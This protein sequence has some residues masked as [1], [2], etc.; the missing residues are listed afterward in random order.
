[1]ARTVLSVV[2]VLAVLSC[3][4]AIE[5]ATIDV[6]ATAAMEGSF[7]L[8]VVCDGIDTSGAYVQDDSPDQESTYRVSFLFNPA[9]MAITQTGSIL[10]SRHFIFTANGGSVNQP[11]NLRVIGV[12]LL[13]KSG[14]YWV[15]A[16]GVN[17]AGGR[18]KTTQKISLGN[19]GVENSP[20]LIEVEWQASPVAGG[21]GVFRFRV[22]GGTWAELS[23]LKNYTQVINTVRLGIVIGLDVDTV[24]SHYYDDFQSFRTLLP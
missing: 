5:A 7:G 1:M 12:Y 23:Y 11:Q 13:K 15:A 2:S 17:T 14:K 3:P 16:Q 20:H 4:L 21:S 24:G 10:E 19:A 18:K 8:E 6:N 9:Q 22:D